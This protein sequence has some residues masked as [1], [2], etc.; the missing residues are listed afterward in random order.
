MYLW[1][2]WMAGA[3]SYLAKQFQTLLHMLDTD[4]EIAMAIRDGDPYK[5]CRFKYFIH[6]QYRAFLESLR[7]APNSAEGV[8]K[9]L[10]RRGHEDRVGLA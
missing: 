1:L 7:L 5:T 9:Q 2:V 6:T 8:T 10:C 3:N 4:T